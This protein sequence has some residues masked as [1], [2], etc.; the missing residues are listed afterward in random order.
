MHGNPETLLAA[1]NRHEAI[2]AE[3]RAL[4]KAFMK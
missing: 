1:A 2:A 3:L 4:V